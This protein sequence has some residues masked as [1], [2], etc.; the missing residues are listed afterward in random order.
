[1]P[2]SDLDRLPREELETV[3]WTPER[4]GRPSAW[5][6]HV[7]FAFWIV[8]KCRPRLLVELGT[9][10]GV[11]YAAFC[12]AVSRL[13]L[14]TKCYAVDSWEGDPH[15]GIYGDDVYVEL[16][17]FHDK[18]YAA[19]SRLV[20]Q[21]FDEALDYFADGS[22]D[23]LHIDGFHTY[24]AVRHDFETWRP[25]L[26]DRAVV[27]FHD[28]NEKQSDFG[29]WR[30][31]SE[32]AQAAPTFEFLHSHGL[33]VVAVGAEVPDEVNQLC[34]L[35]EPHSISTIRERFSFLGARWMTEEEILRLAGQ[36]STLRSEH[37][38]QV[39][40]L[41]SDHT[42]QV[43]ALRSDFDAQISALR[44]DFDAE[45]FALRRDHTAHLS[46]L[47]SDFGAQIS[48]LQSVQASSE[49]QRAELERHAHR[50]EDEL[51]TMDDESR[52]LHDAI[53]QR[54]E[55]DI[56]RLAGLRRAD[57]GGR[58]PSKLTGLR[59][60]IPGRRSESGRLAEDYRAIAGSALF[61]AEWYLSKNPDVA[62][63]KLD[64]ALHYL[65]YGAREGRSPGPLFDGQRYLKEN[66]DVE[67]SNYN[68][69]IHFVRTGWREGR[70]PQ[71]A[72][73]QS[74]C[75]GRSLSRGTRHFN[76]SGSQ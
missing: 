40:A 37:A 57:Y 10:Y 55:H 13:G 53:R 4:L 54:I 6:G 69:L 48:T 47:Q 72:E 39:A 7:P 38:A 25:K 2:N 56:R 11:S 36:I 50:L 34:R 23:L 42:A 9:H 26:S 60:W 3:F 16:R 51:R 21:R 20:R 68:P 45:V 18:H 65:R 8:A 28:S 75:N 5:W 49:Q 61:D 24:E 67:R 17:D 44:S 43:A 76:S 41:R 22:I 15:A 74:V 66:P 30:F 64:P 32:L 1:M 29:V 73:P 46:A 52:V 70:T 35:T 59:R 14:A 58:L 33:G 12:E 63:T 31:L 27:L 62:A 71:A 19:F